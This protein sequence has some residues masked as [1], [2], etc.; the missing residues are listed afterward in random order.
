M[1]AKNRRQGERDPTPGGP[2]TRPEAERLIEKGRLKEAVKQAKIGFKGE[3]TAAN[4]RLLERAYLLRGQ[5]LYRDAMPESAR[6]VAHHL[7]DFGVTDP[8]LKADAA[9]L[10]V[11]VGFAQAALTLSGSDD[12]PEARERLVRQAA[13]QAVLHPDRTSTTLPEIRPGAILVREALEALEAG[14]ENRASDLLRSIARGSPFADWRLFA[15]GLSASRR[16][17]L[18][19]AR[20]N[21]GRLDPDRAPARIA[22]C[23][24]DLDVSAPGGVAGVDL[25]AMEV[26]VFGEPVLGPLRQL[27]D[28]LATDD[29]DEALR[30]LST[31]RFKLRRIDLALAERLTLI[32]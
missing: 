11:S 21:W 15:R 8:A 2:Q 3:P 25:G 22:R 30:L 28:H 26:K 29:W 17:D 32:R 13:D 16:H 19:D 12:A 6:E 1:S 14:D 27:R 4:R 31:V 23:L 9:R 5:Q 24:L 20:A 7:L 18:D 10:L